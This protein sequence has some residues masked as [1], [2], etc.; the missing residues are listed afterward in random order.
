M[1]AA[2]NGLWPTLFGEELPPAVGEGGLLLGAVLAKSWQGV[3][4]QPIEVALDGDVLL[5]LGA[6][7]GQRV[8]RRRLDGSAHPAEGAPVC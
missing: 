3:S 4:K 5:Y 6:L 1:V 2:Q 7:G 8:C